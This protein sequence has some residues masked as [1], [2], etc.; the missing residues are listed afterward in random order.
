MNAVAR[1]VSLGM[2]DADRRVAAL[3]ARPSWDAADRYLKNSAVV[4]AIDRAIAR[5]AV[6]WSCSETRQLTASV[7]EMLT[8][9]PRAERHRAIGTLV[10]TAVIVHVALAVLQGPRPGWFWMVLPGMA[11]VFAL[12]LMASREPQHPL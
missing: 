9:R 2:Q 4:M 6:W 10:L 12:L 5:V 3:L 8:R 1:F 11:A 7:G